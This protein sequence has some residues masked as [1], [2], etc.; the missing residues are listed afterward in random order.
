[1]L[2][3]AD[4]LT[5]TQVRRFESHKLAEELRRS[6]DDLTRMARTYTVTGDARFKNYFETIAAIRDGKE[7]RPKYYQNIFWDFI[8]SNHDYHSGTGREVSIIALMN[9]LRFSEDELSVLAEAKA[10]S[11]NLINME[12][13]AFNAMNGRFIGNDGKYSQHGEPNPEMARE[14]VHSAAYH[15]EKSGIMTKVNEFFRLLKLRT[16]NEVIAAE[17]A[18]KRAYILAITLAALLIIVSVF[19]YYYFTKNI[20]SPLDDL[21][22]KVQQVQDGKY[23]FDFKPRSDEIG[24]LTHAFSNMASIISKTINELEYI[25]RTD[26]LTKI[27]NRTAL[28]KMLSNEKYKFDRYGTN[29]SLILVD[30]DN[31]KEINDKF[32]HIVGDKV[33]VEMAEVM[34]GN[35]RNSDVI[36]R[37]G[38]EEFL[39]ICPNTTLKQAKVIAELMREKVSSAVFS[40]IGRRTASFGVSAFKKSSSLQAVIHTADTALYKAK[41]SGRNKVC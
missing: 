8:T 3:N 12:V 32:G 6:S 11:D 41:A 31:F 39:I 37:W 22:K 15:K 2:D 40:E 17:A 16:L 26:Q 13:K 1:M 28:D 18:Q 10:L 27:N 21:R 7:P 30:I 25:S 14:I 33:I 9:E 34:Q 35:I 5:Q 19:G 24:M 20:I 38:G 23:K 29:C 36:G 4:Q